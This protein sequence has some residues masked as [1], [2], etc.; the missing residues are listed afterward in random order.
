MTFPYSFPVNE[1]VAIGGTVLSAAEAA[2]IDGVTAGA[3]A[4]SKAVVAGS[5][6]KV[7][8]LTFDGAITEEVDGITVAN[9][10]TV[11]AGS[12]VAENGDGRNHVSVITAGEV[13]PAIV[14]GTNLGV[15]VLMYTFPAG[16][17]VVNSVG[18]DMDITQTQSNID[19]DTPEVGI[20]T[21]IA[22]GAVVVLNGTTGFDDILVEQTATGCNGENTLKT[23]A[24][25]VLVI[26]AAGA[27]TVHF[28]AA[29][30]WAASGD[31]AAI[32]GGT[33]TIDWTFLG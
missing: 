22:T 19:A 12:S 2:F 32:V 6:G 18:M 1:N 33:L 9:V 20:G 13:L 3:N 11:A 26:E 21:V 14:G 17:I 24:N 31:S 30:G 4:A 15:G 28:N 16:R 27:H 25:Q 23:V 8:A 7:G 10:G 5:D 29:F